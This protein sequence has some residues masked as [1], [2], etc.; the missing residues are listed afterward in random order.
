[1]ALKEGVSSS[2][3]PRFIVWILIARLP[4]PP[5]HL[6][7]KWLREGVLLA[8][9]LTTNRLQTTACSSAGY[10]CV[11]NASGAFGPFDEPTNGTVPCP[12]VFSALEPGPS[13]QPQVSSVL[14]NS[15]HFDNFT[16]PVAETAWLLLTV[17]LIVAIWM[18]RHNYEAFQYTHY[19]VWFFY[20]AGLIHAW[21]H[22][23]Y[24]AGGLILLGLDKVFRTVDAARPV[25]VKS[26]LSAHG[27]TRVVLDASFL[28][29]R[30]FYAGQYMWLNIPAVSGVEWHP[31]TISSPPS[32]SLVFGN[33]DR[34]PTISF[35]I[36]D[37]GEGTWTSR[38][39]DVAGSPEET[40][41][42][43]AVSVDG[44]HG[45]MGDFADRD[46]VIMCAGGIGITPFASICS[47]ILA[48]SSDPAHGSLPKSLRR[49]ILVWAVRD[50]DLISV[51]ADQVAP[52]IKPPP[53][54][55]VEFTVHIYLTRQ[56][57]AA[58]P[59]SPYHTAHENAR[60]AHDSELRGEAA[61][62]LCRS[63]IKSGRP[64]IEDI[65][66]SAT[67]SSQKYLAAKGSD[68]DLLSCVSS[69]RSTIAMVCGPQELSKQV[70]NAAFS[71]RTGFHSEVFTF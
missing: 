69:E 13:G 23:Y 41:A 59:L 36:R 9:V 35:H 55:S 2:A 38:L 66:H 7:I 67:E 64:P 20:A 54:C 39:A 48:R 26:L 49:V 27:V 61:A 50:I 4:L 3:F 24:T 43:L 40:H 51:F 33:E 65:I 42:S 8:N 12:C 47:E 17:S 53:Q 28:R 52:L 58:D 31:F 34:T 19:A 32:E 1:M 30:P 16:V 21:S 44:P 37:M 14:P 71:S 29:G 60:P 10:L 5:S 63:I 45:R 57:E 18:R 15:A 22:W 70:S 25:R 62:A 68:G 56:A 46:T 11:I 6:Q